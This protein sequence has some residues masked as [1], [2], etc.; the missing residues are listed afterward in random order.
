MLNKLHVLKGGW[1]KNNK[2]HRRPFCFLSVPEMKNVPW[3]IVIS[4]RGFC[5]KA[6]CSLHLDHATFA[7]NRCNS[8]WKLLHPP[9][10]VITPGK[11][12]RHRQ[13]SEHVLSSHERPWVT[14]AGVSLGLIDPRCKLLRVW[15]VQHH[16]VG[17]TAAARV[18]RAE[19]LG[20]R[21]NKEGLRRKQNK[22]IRCWL[23]LPLHEMRNN[24]KRL[25]WKRPPGPFSVS[26]VNLCT[27][28]GKQ[29][30]WGSPDS[31]RRWGLRWYFGYWIHPHVHGFSARRRG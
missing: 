17:M 30:S 25:L 28:K 13:N 27:T 16:R 22:V 14:H 31:G 3:P 23:Q 18:R 26:E 10:P 6:A 12:K 7:K 1:L 15:L 20:E 9:F 29:A 21:E 11:R 2:K 19:G 8:G 24:G 4:K 5:K